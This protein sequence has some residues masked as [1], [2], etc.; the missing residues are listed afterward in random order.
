[1][2]VRKGLELP[3][4]ALPGVSTCMQRVTRH[5]R[6]VEGSRNSSKMGIKIDQISGY[7]NQI[8]TAVPNAGRYMHGQ[9]T[10]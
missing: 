6:C 8:Y 3:K 1:M 7:K 9:G 5:S 10:T 4:V 2:K